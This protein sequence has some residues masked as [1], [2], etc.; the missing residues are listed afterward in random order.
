MR[1]I[2]L[3]VVAWSCAGFAP[4]AHAPQT[5]VRR[6]LTSLK[7]VPQWL[8]F[9]RTAKLVQ[10][11]SNYEK[12]IW[13]SGPPAYEDQVPAVIAAQVRAWRDEAQAEHSPVATAAEAQ[14]AE[15][16]PETRPVGEVTAETAAWT[17]SEVDANG[18]PTGTAPRAAA[19]APKAEPK[20][21]APVSGVSAQR[22]AAAAK[23]LGLE[24]AAATQDIDAAFLEIDTDR[25]GDIDIEELRTVFG[26]DAED[27][28][29]DLDTIEVDGKVSPNEWRQFFRAA[30]TV[31]GVSAARAAAKA[32]TENIEEASA[33]AALE[34][35]R[36]RAS[37]RAKCDADGVVSYNDFGIL[38]VQ[39]ETTAKGIRALGASRT[40]DRVEAE[41]RE[42]EK[43]GN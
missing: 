41:K 24:K 5:R 32:N 29:S 37:W 18:N 23:K 12:P 38:C 7:A 34:W 25:S 42:E 21:I 36:Q 1:I 4:H 3:A 31:S 28:M 40:G 8:Q 13:K 20:V 17:R 22:A 39:P 35:R 10:R 11:I 6:D 43:K 33:K 27:L 15:V 9:P 30:S 16:E 26:T 19:A 2:L 14:A